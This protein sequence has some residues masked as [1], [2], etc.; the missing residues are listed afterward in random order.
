MNETN[1]Q[2]Q[3][4]GVPL[5]AWIIAIISIGGILAIPIWMFLAAS[6]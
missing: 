6:K 5:W 4:R 1:E 3:R 2:E